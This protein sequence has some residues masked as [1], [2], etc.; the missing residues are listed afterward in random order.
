MI[1]LR[2]LNRN[3]VRSAHPFPPASEVF[4][5]IPHGMKFFAVFDAMKGYWQLPVD[6]NDQKYLHFM[7]PFG[8]YRFLRAP[9]GLVHSGDEYC[10]RGD[11]ILHGVENVLKIV[12]DIAIFARTAEEFRTRIQELFER[13]RAHNFTLNKDKIQMP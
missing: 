5:T 13:C 4:T 8:V 3:V 9:M 12:D 11:R 6:E 1:D 2:A 7:T 10:L